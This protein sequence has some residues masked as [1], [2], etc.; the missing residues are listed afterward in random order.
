MSHNSE[1]KDRCFET[2]RAIAS[3]PAL[4][5]ETFA[6]TLFE[7]LDIDAYSFLSADALDQ[8]ASAGLLSTEA[9]AEMGVLPRQ[10][11][12]K[13]TALHEA[14]VYSPA[15]IRADPF[16]ASAATRCNAILSA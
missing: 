14:G 9:V 12:D 15:S 6:D 13:I 4:N 7:G 10:L 1:L 16:W 8:L 3:L 5:D 2:L 11:L